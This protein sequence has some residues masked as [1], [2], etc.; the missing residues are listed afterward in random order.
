M[1]IPFQR[2][3]IGKKKEWQFPSKSKTQHSGCYWMLRLEIILSDSM[4]S[5]RTG[6]VALPPWPP[7]PWVVAAWHVETMTAAPPFERERQPCPLEL[8]SGPVVGVAAWRISDSPS[9]SSSFYL[10]DNTYLQLDSIRE[11]AYETPIVQELNFILSY[12]LCLLWFW[13]AVFLLV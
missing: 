7:W 5:R 13:L 6:A 1:D 4:P 3:G 10:K 2:G 12:S 9:E 11:P 8:Q